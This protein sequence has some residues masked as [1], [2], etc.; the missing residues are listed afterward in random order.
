MIKAQQKFDESLK[1]SHEEA[2]TH[3]LELRKVQCGMH[4][5]HSALRSRGLPWQDFQTVADFKTDIESFV[6]H[7]DLPAF[8]TFV[9]QPDLEAD[10]TRTP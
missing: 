3:F 7:D 5:V 8:E 6:R 2:T 10:H 1:N 4:P 9:T